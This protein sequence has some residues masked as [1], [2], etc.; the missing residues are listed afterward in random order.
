MKKCHYKCENCGANLVID[1]KAESGVCE[2]CGAV[3]YN[4]DAAAPTE[5]H[6]YFGNLKITPAKIILAVSLVAALA[7]AIVILA[8]YFS[9]VFGKSDAPIADEFRHPKAYLYE[10]TY[11]VGEDMDEGEFVAFKDPSKQRGR[12][13]ILTDP[14]AS[15]GTSACLEEYNF[16]NNTYF[17][18]S[19]GTYVKAVDCNVF[20][21]GDKTVEAMA[22]GSFEGNLMLRGG[23]DIPAGNYVLCNDN[24]NLRYSDITC[25]IGGTEYKKR[26]GMRTHL[27]IGEGDYV[28]LTFGKLYSESTVPLPEA[29]DGKYPSGQYKVGLDI[30]AGRYRLDTGN[31]SM[32]AR[33]VLNKD[34]F[35]FFGEDEELSPS[36]MS[37][38]L[39]L[40]DGDYIYTFMITLV[41]QDGEQ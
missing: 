16:A 13:L 19:R 21:V 27:N 7:A 38:Y 39:D 23:T 15:A 26:V 8:L 32:V 36:T 20:R 12:I 29:E 31:A 9:G 24:D 1:A 18:A 2:Y 4:T 10:G 35:A 14:N 28:Y 30:P 3:Y 34:G 11:L 6:H 37:G 17:K 40:K 22:D 33:Y 41:A 5:V 25:V